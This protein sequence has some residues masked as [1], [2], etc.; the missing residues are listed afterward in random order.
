MVAYN[1]GSKNL[2]NNAAPERIVT[3]AAERGL[4]R[5]L[6]VAPVAG[7]TFRDDDRPSVAV[8]GAGF[9]KRHYAGDPLLIG[10]K[11]TLDGE[12]FTVIGAMPVMVAGGGFEPPTFGL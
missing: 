4:F 10:R 2:Q 3:T 9:W 1:T 6:G 12:G 5:M 7:R 11:I 8:V